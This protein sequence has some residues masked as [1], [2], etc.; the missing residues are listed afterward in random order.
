M[1]QEHGSFAV[2]RVL[3]GLVEAWDAGD[4]ETYGGHFALDATY[5]TFTGIAYAGREAIIRSHR[6]LFDTVLKG[7][8]LQQD[9]LDIRLVRPDVA[10]A[11]SRGDTYQSTPR[12]RARKAQTHVLALAGGGWEVVAFHNTQRRPLL[13]RLTARTP[14]KA[15]NLGPKD[16]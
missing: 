10:V 5:T 12:A 8:R 2:R 3:E 4:A 15:G 14:A 11:V 16:G 9:V 1:Q 7:S 13:A 6:A